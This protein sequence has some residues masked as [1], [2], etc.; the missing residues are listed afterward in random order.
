MLKIRN[1]TRPG[2]APA[3]LDLAAGECV[4][5]GGPSGSGKSIFLR[6]IADLDPNQGEVSLEGVA[7]DRTPA[8]VWRRR[9]CYVPAEAGWWADR[10]GGHFPDAALARPMLGRMGLPDD[11]LDWEVARLSTGEKQR[12]A[13]SRA[14]LVEPKVLLLDEPTSGL[15]PETALI[16]ETMLLERLTGGAA[17]VFVTH[18]AAQAERMAGR[19]LRMENGVLSPVSGDPP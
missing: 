18:D 10:V 17:M 12:L 19:R 8:P 1:L 4:A 6:A 14:L 5:L 2:L 13:L 7:R 9:V 15:D 11:T 16:V 3:D